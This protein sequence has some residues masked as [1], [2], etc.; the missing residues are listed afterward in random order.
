MLPIF[1]KEYTARHAA[2]VELIQSDIV[3]KYAF[4]QYAIEQ[5]ELLLQ[6]QPDHPDLLAKQAEL[7]HLNGYLRMANEKYEKVMQLAEPLPLT[8][9]EITYMYQFC[10]VLLTNEAEPFA[11]KDIVAIHHPEKSLIGYHLFWEDDYD[12]PDDQEPSDHEEVWIAYDATIGDVTNV[13]AWFHSRIIQ[14]QAAATEANDNAGRARIRV[15]WGKHGSL[16]KDWQTMCDPYTGVPIKD[17]LKETYKQMQQGGRVNNHPLKRFWPKQFSG[18][19]TDYITFAK[20]VDPLPQLKKKPLLFKTKWV[21]AVLF[22]H[23]IPY[24][25]HPKMEWPER[26]EM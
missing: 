4:Y 26:F 20:K 10:P 2:L 15:E 23:G 22:T 11:L 9:N 18:S 25:F 7:Y 24:N 16:L 12:F 21:N 14:S 3:S 1:L 17:W 19:F 6:A 13:Y 5:I 8:D